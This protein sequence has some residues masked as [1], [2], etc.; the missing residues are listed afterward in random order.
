MAKYR[1]KY[2]KC[3]TCRQAY[4]VGMM[5]VFVQP[6]CPNAL[7]LP[8]SGFFAVGKGTCEDCNY[9]EKREKAL[10]GSGE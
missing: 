10:E 2:Q 3:R 5:L 1:G 9:W 6:E 4:K 7:L 8:R